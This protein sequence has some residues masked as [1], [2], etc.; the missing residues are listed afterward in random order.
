MKTLVKSDDYTCLDVDEC[1]EDDDNDCDVF[2]TCTNEIGSYSCECLEGFDG[3]GFNCTEVNE[4]ETGDHDCH[5]DAT[6][7]NIIGGFNCTC[8]EGYYGDGWEC[9]DGDE[10]ADG[11]SAGNINGINDTYFDT[12]DCHENAGCTN[13]LGGFN[14]TCDQGY[15]GDGVVCEDQ[16][17]CGQADGPGEINGFNETLF[18]TH[19]C[20]EVAT[21]INQAGDYNCTCNDGYSGDG[22]DCAD[23]NECEGDHECDENAICDNLIGGYNCTCVQGY[24]GS[25]FECADVDECDTG[26]HDCDDNALCD[27]LIGSFNC[28]CIE[29]YEGIGTIGE[30]SD[31]DECSDPDL[32]DC[33]MTNGFCVNKE[34]KHRCRGNEGFFE[35]NE[36]G[37]N[38]T[39]WDEC[40]G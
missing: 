28:T 16:D 1:L 23:V 37:T 39:D 13:T 24:D 8:N 36:D 25:G 22:F 12:A 10:C 35:A 32:N 2:A 19:E 5:T 29:G 4:C 9:I 11:D 18:A 6:C 31:I 40:A 15:Y 30:C 14:C 20:D 17:E 27:N 34:G 33:D 26:D 38:C 3:D 7:E 21:C